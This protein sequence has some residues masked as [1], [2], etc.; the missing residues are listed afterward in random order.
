MTGN[1][2]TSFSL[3]HETLRQKG[4]IPQKLGNIA[5]RA[6]A[7]ISKGGLPRRFRDSGLKRAESR[8][9]GGFVKVVSAR[10]D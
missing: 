2:S 8:Y 3:E 10:H 7:H 4:A 5:L 6:A 1:A 9:V